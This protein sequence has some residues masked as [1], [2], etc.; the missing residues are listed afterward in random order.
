MVSSIVLPSVVST[1]VARR[2]G[3]VFRPDGNRLRRRSGLQ[4]LT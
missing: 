2:K 4:A 1:G 3:L